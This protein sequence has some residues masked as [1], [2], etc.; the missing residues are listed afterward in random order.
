VVFV[1]SCTCE[2]LDE[3]E[4]VPG[5]ANAALIGLC[6]GRWPEGEAGCD[7]AKEA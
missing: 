2:A 7:A 3:G 4:L 6:I 5:E 1:G